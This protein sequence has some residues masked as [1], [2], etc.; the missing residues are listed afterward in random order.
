M[1]L[2]IV[3]SVERRWQDQDWQLEAG[4]RGD[5]MEL[6]STGAPQLTMGLRPDK[7]LAH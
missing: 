2:L 4:V 5:V 3:V 6:V 7:P 1:A